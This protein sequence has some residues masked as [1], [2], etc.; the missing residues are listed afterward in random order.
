[1]AAAH[2]YSLAQS[3]LKVEDVSLTLGDNLILDKV[4]FEIRN[5]TRPDAIAGQVVGLL[6]PSGI[7]KTQLFHL[8]AG[9]KQ[10]TAGRV[11]IGDPGQAVERGMVGVVAQHYPL[12]MHRT[13]LGNLMVAGARSGKSEAE[14]K[15]KAAKLLDEFRLSDRA[16]HYPSQLSGGQRQRVAIAQQ[17]MC[18]ESFLLMDEPFSGLDLIALRKVQEL[19]HGISTAHEL[20]TII[21]VTH[22]IAAALEVAD[23]IL[24]LGRN[25]DERG[26]FVPGARIQATYNLI[27]RGLAWRRGIAN[28]PEFVECL[29]EIRERFALL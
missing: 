5:I 18:S 8:L 13:V 22:D 26:K 9:L 6:G 2:S 14:C 16:N 25:S 19:I 7:G 27:E 29:T 28:T 12:F 4:N 3:I 23:T 1:M 10:P 15:A 17:I 11:L 20:N 21:V 24:L